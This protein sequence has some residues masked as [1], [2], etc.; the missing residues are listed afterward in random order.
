MTYDGN[1]NSWGADCD[2]DPSTKYTC[3][4]RFFESYFPE[5]QYMRLQVTQNGCRLRFDVYGPVNVYAWPEEF[6]YAD[7]A[8][9]QLPTS[10]PTTGV[11]SSCPTSRP[12]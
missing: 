10:V 5:N 12:A 6:A 3:T 11:P 4:V 8:P 2:V 9:T 7:F 1:I